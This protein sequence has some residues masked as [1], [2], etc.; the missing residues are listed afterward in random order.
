MQ[1]MSLTDATS[2]TYLDERMTL[3]LRSTVSVSGECQMSD[4]CCHASGCGTFGGRDVIFLI[5]YSFHRLMHVSIGQLDYETSFR[6]MYYEILI[7]SLCNI[8]V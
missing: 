2:V 3:S 1:S 8:Y 4:T 6:H 5:T 7:Y